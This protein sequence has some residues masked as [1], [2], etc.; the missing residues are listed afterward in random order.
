MVIIA[1]GTVGAG[2]VW[3]WLCGLAG[4]PARW[5]V[6]A[7]VTLMLA[8]GAFAGEVGMLTDWPWAAAFVAAAS[9]SLLVH[10][11]WRHELGERYGA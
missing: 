7:V 11:V 4:V 2:A 10:V 6:R 5:S 3:G 8:T 1:C 9:A